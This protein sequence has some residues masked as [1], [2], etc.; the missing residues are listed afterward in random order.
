MP[1]IAAINN[2][3]SQAN[4]ESLE[5]ILY[6]SV[7]VPLLQTKIQLDRILAAAHRRNLA[8][9]ITGMLMY[10]GGEFIQIL[11][12]PKQSIHQTF[13]NHI[14][15]AAGHTAVNIV[16]RNEISNRSF[17]DWTMGFIGSAE[18]ESIIHF[19]LS[20]VLMNMLTAEA[21]KRSLS[22]GVRGFVSI[23]NQMRQSPYR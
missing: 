1:A 14:S 20:G 13:E 12:G 5:E 2:L 7:A 3:L 11:E 16:C 22:V 19:S 9:G 23:Y 21:K 4:S 15:K 10:Y 6:C 18:I 8:A 17:G